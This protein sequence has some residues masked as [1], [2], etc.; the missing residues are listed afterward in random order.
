MTSRCKK[1]CVQRPS[2]RPEPLNEVVRR[3]MQAMP[4]RHSCP[5]V[6]LRRLLHRLG[7][8]YRLHRNGL[9]GRSDAVFRRVKVAVF[10]DGCFWHFCLR[11]CVSPKNHRMRRD[12]KLLANRVRDR[13][14]DRALSADGWLALHV[15]EHENMDAAAGRV[16]KHVQRRS[17]PNP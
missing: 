1:G 12:A 8:R 14:N 13:R 11:N 5:E 17:A 10:V 9:P 7:L 15:R 6:S 3:N 16:L 2:P 4:T